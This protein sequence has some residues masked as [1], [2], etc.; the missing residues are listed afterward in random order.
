MKS[1]ITFIQFTAHCCVVTTRQQMGR[2]YFFRDRPGWFVNE[3]ASM[4]I[5]GGESPGL[6]A[7]IT[8]ARAEQ[9]R[10]IDKELR[11]L[12]AMLRQSGLTDLAGSVAA[13]REEVRPD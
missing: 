3:V 10:R 6:V 2:W 13:V 7:M 11:D 9:A 4:P 8:E 12:E 5:K 1:I